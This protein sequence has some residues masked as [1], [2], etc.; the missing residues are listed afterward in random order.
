MLYFH[1]ILSYIDVCVVVEIQ[2]YVSKHAAY[3]II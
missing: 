2:Y 3:I 1:S